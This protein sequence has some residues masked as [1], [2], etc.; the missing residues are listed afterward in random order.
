MEGHV[1]KWTRSE[2]I[3]QKKEEKLIINIE[4]RRKTQKL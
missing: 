1:D 2:Y 4:A 3:I